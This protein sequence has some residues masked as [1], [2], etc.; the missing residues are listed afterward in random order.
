MI[1]SHKKIQIYLYIN[2]GNNVVRHKRLIAEPG[3]SALDALDRA[4]DIEY[5]YSGHCLGCKG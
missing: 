1:F 5:T 3:I 2:Y 4:A